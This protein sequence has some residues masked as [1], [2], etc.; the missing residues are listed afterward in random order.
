MEA[1]GC[2]W[3]TIF[4]ATTPH[5]RNGV[6]QI[7]IIAT[8]TAASIHITSAQIQR[9][10]TFL[11]HDTFFISG[12]KHPPFRVIFWTLLDSRTEETIESLM[13]ISVPASSIGC[14]ARSG[15]H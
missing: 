1:E 6:K 7:H 11:F 15:T 14:T 8:P 12:G 3:E 2:W 9:R 10:T 5:V 13:S 4:I